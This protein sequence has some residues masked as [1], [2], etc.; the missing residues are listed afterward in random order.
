MI[1]GA[2]IEER[3]TKLG[4][5]QSHLARRVGVSQATIAGLISGRSSGSKHLHAIARELQTTPQ[6]LTGET[7]DPTEGALPAP[8]PAMIAEQLD[9][10]L[11]PEL[12]LGYSMGGGS[13]FHDYQQTGVVPFQKSWLRG[14][15]RGSISELFVARGRGD[16][17]EP[18]LR[19]GDIIL[20]DTAQMQIDQQD[21]IWALSYGDLGMIK[22]VRKLP[23]G[24]YEIN[25]DNK[26]VSAISAY[27]GEMHIVGRVIW[28]GRWM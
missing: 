6:Y 12:A 10:A 24:G 17:M 25:S 9:V 19:D 27:D 22:R 2:R 1:I 7:D 11:V 28:I 14:H 8:T 18:T 3:L 23:G 20:V 15:A 4:W 21:A 5:S 16:S 26:N 13:V